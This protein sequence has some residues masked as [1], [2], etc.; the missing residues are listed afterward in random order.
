MLDNRPPDRNLRGIER[1]PGLTH[2]EFFGTPDREELAALR[3]LPLLTSVTVHQPDTVEEIVRLPALRHMAVD[4]IS[5][6]RHPTVLA[7]LQRCNHLSITLDG[8]G[9]SP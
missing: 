4:G 9:I 2:A 7:T 1:F 3:R 8:S 6:A 5:A